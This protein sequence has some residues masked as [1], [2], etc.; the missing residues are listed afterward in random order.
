MMLGARVVGGVA[1]LPGLGLSF[2]E[3]TV[4]SLGREPGLVGFQKGDQSIFSADRCFNPRSY[5]S[6]VHIAALRCCR[7]VKC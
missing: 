7:G 6:I 2:L 1:V 5:A 4:K 3:V